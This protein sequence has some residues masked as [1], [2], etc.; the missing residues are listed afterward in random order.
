MNKS[1]VIGAC[2]AVI[3]GGAVAAMPLYIGQQAEQAI[4]GFTRADFGE[5]QIS[6]R[7][8]RY[9]SGYASATADA[10]MRFSIPQEELE[11]AFTV[12]HR[13]RH[14]IV[15]ATVDSDFYPLSQSEEIRQA[16]AGFFGD[17]AAF[18]TTTAAGRDGTRI[19]LLVPAH[20]T[21]AESELQV[22]IDRASGRL[23]I[24][25]ETMT[26]ELDVPAIRLSADEAKFEMIGQSLRLA[27]A[28]HRDIFA[29]SSLS[30]GIERIGLADADEALSASDILLK[31]EQSPNGPLLDMTSVLTI[32]QLKASRGELERLSLSANS[33]NLHRDAMEALA[34][35]N[36][37]GELALDEQGLEQV[38]KAFLAASPTA[39]VSLTVGPSG[40][41]GSLTWT[42][43][44]AAE[45]GVEVSLADPLALLAGVETR[46]LLDVSD[47]ALLEI[48]RLGDA[49]P[50]L[51]LFR[52]QL[53]ALAEDGLLV[54]T[55]HGYRATA[56]F[57]RGSFLI[58]DRPQPELLM[59]LGM[60]LMGG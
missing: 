43:G 24:A 25:A 12:R 7:I 51:D 52:A 20:R 60:L 45:A 35:L 18:S 28:D 46:L 49:E 31:S 59:L 13:I 34:Q 42:L 1:V 55:E 41:Q 14:G 30:Y 53:A 29:R 10:V 32:G 40:E 21:P 38:A 50:G 26:G 23:V 37:G 22:H 47:A 36:A 9:D 15:G 44:Y 6:H 2:V 39:E 8:E 48:A 11:L 19:D 4:T 27:T 3:A 17:R 56:S 5:L 57:E 33:T 54:R 58:N 16:L